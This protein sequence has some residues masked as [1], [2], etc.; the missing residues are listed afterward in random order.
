MREPTR[1]EIE[2]FCATVIARLGLRVDDH[3]AEQARQVLRHRLRRTNCDC[4]AAYLERFEDPLFAQEELGEAA[5]EFSVAETYFFRHPEQFLAMVETAIPE[6]MRAREST[7][8][9]RV[10]SAGCASGEEPY[11]LAAAIRTAL[12]GSNGWD[13]RIWGIDVN[14][15]LLKQAAHARYRPWSLR[16]TTDQDRQL[17]FHREGQDHILDAELRSMVTFEE[18]NLLDDDPS[19]WRPD[20]FDLIFCRNVMIYFTRAATAQAVGRLA[21]SLAP[22]GFLFLGPTETLRGITQEFHLRHTHGAFYYQRRYPGEITDRSI[23]FPGRADSPREVT[24]V[25]TVPE[26]HDESW[27]SAISQA[28]DRIAALAERSDRHSRAIGAFGGSGVRQENLADVAGEHPL[29]SARNLFRQ[30]RFEDALRE[31]HALPS[32]SESDP[33]ALLLRAVLLANTGQVTKAQEIC[34]ALLA[35]D[36][37]NA[38]AH[39]L[40]AVCREHSGEVEA[41]TEHDQ[42]AIYLDPGFAMPRLHLGLLAKRQGDLAGARRELGEALELLAREDASRILLFGG[43]FHRDALVRYCQSQLRHCGGTP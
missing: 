29:E 10:L 34:R 9:L 1:E 19:F 12:A 38:G 22:G 23:H 4:V 6:R 36:E 25:L 30:E 37:L 16:A 11:S 21:H 43:G 27:V 31:L 42:T 14:A 5:A 28:A 20:Y 13:V 7:R 26:R 24:P 40:M 2:Q 15:R 41:A 39:Y 35:T 8:R 33:D 32:Q 17:Y 3:N 18:R